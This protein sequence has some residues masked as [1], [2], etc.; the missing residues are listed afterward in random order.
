M[1]NGIPNVIGFD[2]KRALKETKESLAAM[3]PE[4]KRQ[5]LIKSGILTKTG[6]VAKPYVEVIKP[7]P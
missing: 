7:M 3:T 6:R 2:V 4:K 5:L 1:R